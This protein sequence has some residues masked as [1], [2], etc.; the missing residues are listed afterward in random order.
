MTYVVDKDVPIPAARGAYSKY[1]FGDVE[2]GDSFIVPPGD[3]DP[4]VVANRVQVAA[5][6]FGRRNGM[7]FTTRST[8]QGVRVWRV[9]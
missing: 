2:V 9:S 6:G 3:I 4:R 1:P 5:K 7:L 8:S